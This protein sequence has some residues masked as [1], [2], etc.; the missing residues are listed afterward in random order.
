VAVEVLANEDD[1][2]K[3]G[4]EEPEEDLILVSRF[5]EEIIGALVLRAPLQPP[6]PATASPLS[7]TFSTFPNSGNNDDDDDDNDCVSTNNALIRAWTVKIR[8]RGKGIGTGL[9]EAAVETC[10]KRGWKGP[11]FD[12]AHANAARVFP[13]G[14]G[15]A[16]RTLFKFNSRFDALET[17][18]RSA[19]EDAKS[20]TLSRG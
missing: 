2:D 5:G 15:S 9:L 20:R 14:G 1:T 11:F 12:E 16:K 3:D 19:L 17:K 8:Y 10:Q 4:K 7:S 13:G 6:T 18:A